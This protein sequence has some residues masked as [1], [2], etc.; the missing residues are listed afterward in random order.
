MCQGSLIVVLTSEVTNV[1]AFTMNCG[2]TRNSSGIP[3][4]YVLT[5]YN[6]MDLSL[7]PGAR[8]KV[9]GDNQL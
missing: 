3:N 6:S 2:S 8:V 4:M 5:S 7:L 1:C 9:N